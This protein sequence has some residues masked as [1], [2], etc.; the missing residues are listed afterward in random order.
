M[1]HLGLSEEEIKG[2]LQAPGTFIPT[3][4]QVDRARKSLPSW[5]E[6]FHHMS[7]DEFLRRAFSAEAIQRKTEFVRKWKVENA[8]NLRTYQ[9]MCGI[10]HAPSRKKR[11]R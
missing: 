6:E 7:M 2:Y 9:E 5:I 10:R 3:P 8:R 4:A 1:A 11:V